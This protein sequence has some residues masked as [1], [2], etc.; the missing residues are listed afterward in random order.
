MRVRPYGFDGPSVQGQL[1]PV[2]Q[3]NLIQFFNRNPWQGHHIL[4]DFARD[5]GRDRLSNAQR[6]FPGLQAKWIVHFGDGK[7]LE[8]IGVQ[9]AFG[10]DG[11]LFSVGSMG[12]L[13]NRAV[14]GHS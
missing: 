2:H 6:W 4:E 3:V 1:S 11:E 10:A 12:L 14:I 5:R 9:G 7:Q 8:S 13:N